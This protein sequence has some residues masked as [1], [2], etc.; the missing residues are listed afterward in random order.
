MNFPANSREFDSLPKKGNR[1]DA[2]KRAEDQAGRA[3]QHAIKLRI[4]W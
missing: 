3:N 2:K 1:L 4:E